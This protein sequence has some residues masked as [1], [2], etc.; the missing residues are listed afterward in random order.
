MKLSISFKYLFV[1]LLSASVFLG[2][3]NKN[4]TKKVFA[5]SV[6]DLSTDSDIKPLGDQT[7]PL[8]N[9]RFGVAVSTWDYDNLL[10][11]NTLGQ[12]IVCAN[13]PRKMY[14]GFS[15]MWVTSVDGKNLT[16]AKNALNISS[17]HALDPNANT[18]FI[19]FHYENMTN[20]RKLITNKPFD[21][22]TNN[23]ENISWVNTGIALDKDT[24]SL[25]KNGVRVYALSGAPG[26]IKVYIQ[27]EESAPGSAPQHLNSNWRIRL[28]G[29]EEDSA[30]HP[31]CQDCIFNKE[32]L[33]TFLENNID[34]NDGND[35]WYSFYL[36]A[37]TEFGIVSHY[38]DP[39]EYA[40]VV[41]SYTKEII[42]LYPK[43]KII[44]QSP[45]AGI[46]SSTGI[47]GVVNYKPWSN[48]TNYY[49]SLWN[50]Y[51]TEDSK[52][53]VSFIGL[54]AFISNIEHPDTLVNG[55]RAV[56]ECEIQDKV[57]NFY[58]DVKVVGSSLHQITGKDIL[59]TQSGGRLP[60]LPKE[61]YR[62]AS[63]ITEDGD[64]ILVKDTIINF[65][66]PF[67]CTWCDN[68]NDVWS[69]T[70]YSSAR[71]VQLAYEKLFKNINDTHVVAWAYWG[72]GKQPFW[73][74][75]DIKVTWGS[76]NHGVMPL[77]WSL[78]C[79]AIGQPN[80]SANTGRVWPTRT[81][82]VYLYAANGDFKH[83]PE[84]APRWW[85]REEKSCN[86]KDYNNDVVV[87]NNDTI[88]LTQNIFNKAYGVP[89]VNSILDLNKDRRVDLFDLILFLNL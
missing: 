7:S 32:D 85:G 34:F 47:D 49:N 18:Q 6:Y 71:L 41:N 36:L 50:N 52:N 43:A 16:L 44:L 75:P 58:N 82:E 59:L 74:D 38:L 1:L 64:S 66:S 26:S 69:T 3:F 55:V 11:Y 9:G 76:I 8:A 31:F 77:S 73:Y 42:K 86:I 46:E 83:K 27:N 89:N 14:P 56:T 70:E 72:N 37:E 53:A 22:Q 79:L 21:Y 10:C 67:E 48:I 81:G 80:C 63:V 17:F 19:W 87:D 35:G 54:D 20:Y 5:E 12:K 15:D 68:I 62:D 45:V 39:Y 2:V 24:L 13:D 51:L 84:G 23:T 40:S 65:S 4:P 78:E 61:K 28:P 30:G 29:I 25:S 57:N 88:L 33:I 60:S